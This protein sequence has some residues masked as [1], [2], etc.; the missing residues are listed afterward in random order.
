MNI[1]D[2]HVWYWIDLVVIGIE[3][4]NLVVSHRHGH[5]FSP[6]NSSLR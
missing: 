2:C 4:E 5:V 3:V 1:V 6:A